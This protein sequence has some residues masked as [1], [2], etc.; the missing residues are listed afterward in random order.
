MSA[1]ALRFTAYQRRFGI[2]ATRV[3]A[4]TKSRRVGGTFM[5]AASC[6]FGAASLALTAD[7]IVRTRDG[8]EHQ[9]IVSHSEDGAIR[10]LAECANLLERFSRAGIVDRDS[11]IAQATSMKIVLASGVEL[12]AHASRASSLRGLSGS[13]FLDEWAYVPSAEEVWRAVK[14]VSDATLARP[15][16]RITIC[17]TP[18]VRDSLAFEQCAGSGDAATDRF[19]FISRYHWPLDLC[20]RQG[21]P[22]EFASEDARLEFIEDTRA[23]VADPD[24]WATEYCAQWADP[25][26]QWLERALLERAQRDE[27]PDGD[28]VEFAGVD[29]GRKRHATAIARVRVYAVPTPQG[30]RRVMYAMPVELLRETSFAAQEEAFVRV[31]DG[32]ARKLFADSTGIGSAPVERLSALRPGRVEAVTF[33]LASKEQMASTLKLALEE[34]RLF[35]PHSPELL[36]SLSSVRRTASDASG[37]WK[38]DAP[39]HGHDHADAAWALMLAVS[40]ATQNAGAAP[41]IAS[42]GRRESSDVA[43]H[44]VGNGQGTYR[45]PAARHF[46]EMFGRGRRPPGQGTPWG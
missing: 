12:S 14:A 45:G 37:A 39:A 38:Y 30:T 27:L 13:V 10:V 29:I 1:P 36:R 4:I 40:A 16:A 33:S 24:A 18:W 6:V 42:A 17:T 5:G 32:G 44:F 46:P 21:F 9:R 8:G 43:D 26:S 22:H 35:L 7:G 3:R 25:S 19:S 20:T 11:R 34:N 2:D 41:S 31:I 15:A 23:T 28:F